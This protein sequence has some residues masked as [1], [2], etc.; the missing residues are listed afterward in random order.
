MAMLQMR[1]LRGAAR[2][3]MRTR[4]PTRLLSAD[5]AAAPVGVPAPG[6]A[7]AMSAK[8]SALVDEVVA[9]NMLEVKE[10][11][12]ALKDRLGIDD[13]AAMPMMSPAMMAAM[14]QGGAPA[15]AAEPVVEKTAFDLKLAK[16]D[17]AKKIAVIKEVRA[18]T[19]LGLK[20]AKALVESAPKV[21]KSDVAK[22]EAEEIRDKLS[23]LGGTVELE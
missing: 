17:P 8:V 10:L 21:F 2:H 3:L 22:A 16:F 1:A 15:A 4:V 23:Q 18:I 13:S 12:D 11:T 5:V 19:G 6:A 9:L 14:S 7:G 20:E